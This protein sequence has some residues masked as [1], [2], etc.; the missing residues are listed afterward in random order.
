[1][2]FFDHY[3]SIQSF[4]T[5]TYKGN[6][7]VIC[8]PDN[9]FEYQNNPNDLL[10]W[11][12]NNS[13]EL[14]FFYNLD[15]DTSVIIKSFLPLDK[16]IKNT[17][18]FTYGNYTFRY[19]SGKS[20]SIQNRNKHGKRKIF[21]YFDIAQFYN[22]KPLDIMAK[23]FL[24]DQKNNIELELNSK[25]IGEIKGYYEE[26]REDIITYCKKDAWL[27]L[28]LAKIT[29]S[30]VKEF[31]GVIP[32][33]WYSSA[34][35]AKAYMNLHHPDLIN[36]YY[37]TLK[38]LPQQEQ[39][40]AHKIIMNS[41]FGGLFYI[42]KLGRNNNQ[43]EY[44][45]NS[46]Y[47]DQIR[48]LFNLQNAEIRTVKEYTKADYGF[49]HVRIR[50]L[51]DLPIHYRTGAT[52][53]TYIRSYDYVE[54]Y[55]TDIELEY[56]T[57]H[58]SKDIQFEIIKGV[59]I[60]TD[61]ILELPE[62]IDLYNKRANIKKQMKACPDKKQYRT[63]DIEQ[64]NIKLILN[65]SYGIF[66][67]KRPVFTR[68]T[69]F[70]Y[71]AYITAGTR[72]KM[73]EA[74][75]RI[76]WSHVS[77]IMTDAIVT[78]IPIPD[79]DYNNTE[80]GQFKLEGQFDIVWV[81]QNGVYIVKKDNRFILHT[82]GFPTN[83]DYK[84]FL[85]GIGNT[86]TIPKTSPLKLKEGIIQNRINEIG[87]FIQKD[88]VFDLHA[89]RWKYL[90][91]IDKLKFEYLKDNILQTNYLLNSELEEKFNNKPFT[92]KLLLKELYQK[93][94]K[95]TTQI[96]IPE[97]KTI[98]SFDEIQTKFDTIVKGEHRTRDFNRYINRL[99]NTGIDIKDLGNHTFLIKA[100]DKE[101]IIKTDYH[102]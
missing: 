15:F 43:Y 57:K 24:N 93:M 45:L 89:N 40:D 74:I 3:P 29:V 47:P 66:A 94:N 96:K 22:H 77:M 82:R 73:Y 49:Y 48:K 83:L 90:L 98:I 33:A 63:L 86:I 65:S 6:L 7:K 88:R 28:E 42:H 27:T 99:R 38:Q 100:E 67:Q 34:S 23:T 61:H 92:Q 37:T 35:I 97:S 101:L 84:L 71:A 30:G 50:N 19:L 72:L 13:K 31:L 18:K 52:E 2:N 11:L 8:S 55:F 81:Y 39:N 91:D 68:F 75:D 80:L 87:S 9:Y 69:N 85:D 62:F 4:D 70:I 58:H 41:Y 59:I 46:A 76:G 10:K 17:G 12:V 36:T 20:F 102:N 53:I 54:N 32:K 79:P 1:M 26:H 14:N 51:S 25:S 95:P 64:G 5:E 60:N 16:R 56:F 21:R 78:D 44:D